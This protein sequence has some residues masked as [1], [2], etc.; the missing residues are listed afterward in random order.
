MKNF[1]NFL[2]ESIRDK[3]TGISYEEFKKKIEND[4]TVV[5]I[6][7]ER[8]DKYNYLMDV[9]KRCDYEGTMH[10]FVKD[11]I[12]IGTTGEHNVY[13]NYLDVNKYDDRLSFWFIF[14]EKPDDLNGTQWESG[15]IWEENGVLKQ[16]EKNTKITLYPDYIDRIYKE[17][18]SY[19][20]LDEWIKYI[21]D[22]WTK[23]RKYSRWAQQRS[24][25]GYWKDK[26]KPKD[27]TWEEKL[28][29]AK[30][31]VETDKLLNRYSKP[32]DQR[33]LDEM[34]KLG[35]DAYTKLAD[36]RN[37]RMMKIINGMEKDGTFDKIKNK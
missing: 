36:E 28:D 9:T 25:S 18:K 26:P 5:D 11:P 3:M 31:R 23:S 17:I 24:D 21:V 34:E 10:F 35:E 14:D 37:A 1:K 30:T 20:D 29:W 27:L 13:L 32:Y 8:D 12:E 6:Q 15:V 19:T 22:V 4:N 33:E 2:G 7:P 16:T